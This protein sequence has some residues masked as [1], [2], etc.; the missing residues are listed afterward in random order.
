VYLTWRV[1]TLDRA[2]R[3]TYPPR[4]ILIRHAESAGNVD[5]DAYRTIGDPMIPLTVRGRAQARAMAQE[6]RKIVGDRQIWAFT[7]PYLR[8]RETAT[9]AL[10][11]FPQSSWRLTED[12]RLREQEFA[13]GFQHSVPD[14]SEQRLYSKFFWRFPGGESAADVYDRMSM[15]MDTLWRDLYRV[16]L[17]QTV[18]VIFAHGLTNRLFCMRWLHWSPRQ[19]ETTRNPPNCGFIELE[20]Q[21]ADR[22]GNPYYRLTHDSLEL[23]GLS[24][25]GPDGEPDLAESAPSTWVL[26]RIYQEAPLSARAARGVANILGVGLSSA[27]SPAPPRIAGGSGWRL[28]DGPRS[29]RGSG[30]SDSADEVARAVPAPA[31]VGPIPRMSSRGPSAAA[32]PAQPLQGPTHQFDHGSC[33]RPPRASS[34]TPARSREHA[35]GATAG[36]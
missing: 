13:G 20:L 24:G 8:S 14:R 3:P 34:S 15:F 9:I 6:L 1:R 17:S 12:P 10:Q 4:I 18:V 26:S 33:A 27:P 31:K 19:F 32:A 23:L 30:H 5:V 7:S 22:M 16:D 21:P 29:A 2:R 28:R 35:L 25:D 11:A 36:T